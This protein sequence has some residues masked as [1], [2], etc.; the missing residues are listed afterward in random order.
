MERF[1]GSAILETAEKALESL[2]LTKA[3]MG[4]VLLLQAVLNGCGEAG[5]TY[6]PVFLD[7]TVPEET[8]KR[9]VLEATEPEEEKLV[10][11]PISAGIPPVEVA[12]GKVEELPAPVKGKPQP[13]SVRAPAPAA[14][15]PKARTEAE[16]VPVTAP[17]SRMDLKEKFFS[18]SVDETACWIPPSSNLR[19]GS[20]F[21]LNLHI[22]NPDGKKLKVAIA[23]T[24]PLGA[25][26]ELTIEGRKTSSVV[27]FTIQSSFHGRLDFVVTDKKDNIHCS[28]LFSV[29]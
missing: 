17:S 19:A 22:S 15:R 6:Q 28:R 8:K 26:R 10:L 21:D 1:K 27:N 13:R 25:V 18:D 4:T 24:P 29:E 5:D 23:T 3:R 12:L 16:P 2:G 9:A 14:A 11:K 7:D 20:S